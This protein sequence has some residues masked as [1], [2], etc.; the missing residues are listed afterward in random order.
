M[1][2][3]S[4]KTVVQQ[5]DATLATTK[6]VQEATRLTGQQVYEA[7]AG[8]VHSGPGATLIG[9]TEVVAP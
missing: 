2:N 4:H 9:G 1:E 8:A 3:V 7:R 5:L 6:A